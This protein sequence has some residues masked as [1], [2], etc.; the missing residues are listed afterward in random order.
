MQNAAFFL[1]RLM[2]SLRIQTFQDFEIV[3]T[4]D[5]KMAE[6]TNAA[7]KKAKGEIVKIMYLDDYLVYPDSLQIMVDDFKGGWLATGCLHDDGTGLFN[8]HIPTWNDR[9]NEGANT[10][11]SPS[12]IMIENDNPI[13]FDETM[14]WLLDCDYYKRLY[15]RY[16]LPTLIDAP[17]VAIGV[18]PGQMTN[19]LTD[20]QKLAEHKYI[21]KKYA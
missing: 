2:A 3:I 20:D 10:I 5:G 8:H 11:G 4:K 14:S 18:H 7:I 12:V 21:N 13:M 9:I 16:G 15:E 19:I 6:N 1:E 17:L